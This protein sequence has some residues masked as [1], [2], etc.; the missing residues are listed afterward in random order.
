[1]VPISRRAGV[2]EPDFRCAIPGAGLE[3]ACRNADGRNRGDNG[4]RDRPKLN[5][6]YTSSYRNSNLHTPVAALGGSARPWRFMRCS[7]S[8]G[9][10]ALFLQSSFVTVAADRQFGSVPLARRP[11]LATVHG[12]L[13]G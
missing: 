12:A 11:A 5:C 10:G 9:T 4:G 2:V 6:K 3:L 8:R 7:R 1:M 13:L